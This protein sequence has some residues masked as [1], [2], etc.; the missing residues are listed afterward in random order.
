MW[1]I[2]RVIVW[3]L[4][5]YVLRVFWPI[6]G[7]LFMSSYVGPMNINH[8]DESSNVVPHRIHI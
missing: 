7:K 1:K 3:I 4:S 5:L 6:F 2:R 8:K